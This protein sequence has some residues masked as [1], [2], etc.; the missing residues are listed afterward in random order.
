MT[1]DKLTPE[2]RDK[3]A[4]H[5]Y[6]SMIVGRPWEKVDQKAKDELLAVVDAVAEVLAAEQWHHANA[7]DC[8]EAEHDL[9]N[10][11]A[12]LQA[13]AG[14]VDRLKA[15]KARQADRIAELEDPG[16]EENRAT[17]EVTCPRDCEPPCDW[18][19]TTE[20][21]LITHYIDA[22]HSP[23]QDA[24]DSMCK[25]YWKHLDT[26][27]RNAPVVTAARALVYNEDR[28]AFGTRLAELVDAVKETVSDAPQR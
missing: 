28:D 10:L 5:A 2:V 12:Q 26:V 9:I 1:A 16:A 22:H 25:A 13:T 6:E 4:R 17:A 11:R 14:E 20:T 3:A 8:A 15:E 24:Y 18:T 23:T 21:E 19:G 27:K 7:A